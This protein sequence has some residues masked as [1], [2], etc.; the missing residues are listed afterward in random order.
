M[1]PEYRSEGVIYSLKYREVSPKP[2]P[3]DHVDIMNNNIKVLQLTLVAG[4]SSCR[5]IHSLSLCSFRHRTEETRKR[6]VHVLFQVCVYDDLKS[7]ERR[8]TN[9]H[10]LRKTPGQEGAVE[11]ASAVIQGQERGLCWQ[12]RLYLAELEVLHALLELLSPL[13]LWLD[14]HVEHLHA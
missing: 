5:R 9:S 1:Y 14:H 7:V 2:A 10:S 6:Y 11:E 8:S 12:W 3:G 4:C 13:H